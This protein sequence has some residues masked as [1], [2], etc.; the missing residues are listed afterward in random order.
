MFDLDDI[1]R[2]LGGERSEFQIN[3]P[4]PGHSPRDRS[5]AVKFSG[6]GSFVVHS[7]AGDDFGTCRD[8][9]RSCIDGLSLSSTMQPMRLVLPH[10]TEKNRARANHLWACR[11]DPVD[12]PVR[13]YLHHR[14]I[15]TSARRA[16]AISNPAHTATRP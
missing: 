7:H 12:T 2:R 4:G 3:C 6:N 9:V 14:G 13:A 1:A 5:L 11:K 8:F 16:S 10:E 15:S